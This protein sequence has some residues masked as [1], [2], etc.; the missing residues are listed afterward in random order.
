MTRNTIL[1]KA[2]QETTVVTI[3]LQL[4]YIGFALYFDQLT[5]IC[6]SKATPHP[7]AFHLLRKAPSWE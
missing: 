3:I 2:H 5:N 4:A 7:E 1:R 6:A